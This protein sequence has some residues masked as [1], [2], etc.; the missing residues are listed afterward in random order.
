MQYNYENL[1]LINIYMPLVVYIL[2][3]FVA[4]YSQSNI[5]V[6]C[7]SQSSS[8]WILK[9]C[10]LGHDYRI[11]GVLLPNIL[12]S[13]PLTNYR[14]SLTTH[15]SQDSTSRVYRRGHER[16]WFSNIIYNA[17]PEHAMVIRALSCF[18]KMLHPILDERPICVRFTYSD[19]YVHSYHQS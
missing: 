17:P 18:S 10:S 11:L 19:P 7:P 2:V 15:R 4:H 1:Y 16:T 14:S 3:I 13:S 12:F 6:V 5:H 9:I 8:F